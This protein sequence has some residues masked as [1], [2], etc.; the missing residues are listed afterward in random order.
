MI[1]IMRGWKREG[2]ST[3]QT[4]HQQNDVLQLCIRHYRRAAKSASAVLLLNLEGAT[5]LSDDTPPRR[6]TIDQPL[7]HQCCSSALEIG[8]SSVSNMALCAVRLLESHAG[9]SASERRSLVTSVGG[10]CSRALRLLLQRPPCSYP[11][12]AGHAG[13]PAALS[14]SWKLLHRCAKLY[15]LG[16]EDDKAKAQLTELHA[17]LLRYIRTK[18]RAEGVWSAAEEPLV[19]ETNVLLQQECSALRWRLEPSLL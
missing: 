3:F 1:V 18:Q 12:G 5:T 9:L 13:P 16:E 7:L 14:M 2:N 10:S 11:Q 15:R 19:G 17:S 8:V 6:P 4:A